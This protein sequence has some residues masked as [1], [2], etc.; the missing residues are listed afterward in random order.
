MDQIVHIVT[1]SLLPDLLW[2]MII[3]LFCGKTVICTKQKTSFL[4]LLK[5]LCTCCWLLFVW[6]KIKSSSEVL[7]EWR[8][9]IF[10]SDIN[11]TLVLFCI[12]IFTR[13]FLWHHFGKCLDSLQG[14]QQK[15][16]TVLVM[17]LKF[18]FHLFLIY[19]NKVFK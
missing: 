4:I 16:I 5:N 3:G 13:N 11:L 12:S 19:W 17:K 7:K 10:L 9:K 14:Y 2:L 18:C 15:Y 8:I 1:G 6:A